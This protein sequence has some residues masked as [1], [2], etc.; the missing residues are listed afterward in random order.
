M[1]EKLLIEG[2]DYTISCSDNKD[3]GTA[4]VAITFVGNYKGTAETAFTIKAKDVSET[5]KVE[6]IVDQT[7]TGNPILPKLTVK[8]GDF[9]LEENKDYSVAYEKNVNVAESPAVGKIAFI[10]NYAG[11]AEVSFKIV[12]ATLNI[13][14]LTTAWN[15]PIYQIITNEQDVA[16]SLY[17]P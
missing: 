6:E 3:V 10:G 17:S 12:P 16:D 15:Q 7:Y 13:E 8:D 14:N 1:D 11:N 5:V 9:V 4:R 2:K